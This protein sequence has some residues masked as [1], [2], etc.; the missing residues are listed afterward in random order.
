MFA[1]KD[2]K[3]LYRVGSK[4]TNDY[5]PGVEYKVASKSWDGNG[6]LSYTLTS[7]DGGRL[8]G[9]PQKALNKA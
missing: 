7:A 6:S 8:A 3:A 1:P 4:V 2:Q 5:Y 9:V